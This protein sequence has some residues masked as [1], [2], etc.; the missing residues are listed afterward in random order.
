MIYDKLNK[1]TGRLTYDI[2]HFICFFHGPKE[3]GGPWHNALL[4]KYANASKL[5][6]FVRF[7]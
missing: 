5:R 2:W 6:T 4:L 3:G 7:P 1:F